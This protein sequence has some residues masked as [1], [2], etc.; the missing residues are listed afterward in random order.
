MKLG[1]FLAFVVLLASTNVLA[2]RGERTRDRKNRTRTDQFNDGVKPVAIVH[3][4]DK[5]IK[6]GEHNSEPVNVVDADLSFGSD[7]G[8]RRRPSD[9]DDD[10]TRDKTRLRPGQFDGKNKNRQ[11]PGRFNDQDD[12][13]DHDDNNRTPGEKNKERFD[14]RPEDHDDEQ[15]DRRPGAKNKDRRPEDHD[16]EKIDRRPGAKN[17]DHRPEDRDDQ[18]FDRKPP[19]PDKGLHFDEGRPDNVDLSNDT[20]RERRPVSEHNIFTHTVFIIIDRSTF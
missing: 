16:D 11:S 1:L 17:K 9:D 18:R 19:R 20:V 7:E 15:I 3:D 13:G 6:I 12:N 8:R 5:P 14:R 4:S 10:E 2:Q